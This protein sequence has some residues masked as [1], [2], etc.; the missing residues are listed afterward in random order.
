MASRLDGKHDLATVKVKIDSLFQKPNQLIEREGIFHDFNF[1][2]INFRGII[3]NEKILCFIRV[4]ARRRPGPYAIE[5]IIR[6]CITIFKEIVV[7][8]ASVSKVGRF[9]LI[10]IENLIISISVQIGAA[11]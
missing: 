9:V 4:S 2:S 11:G 8:F 5:S 3:Y 7:K 6:S 1:D 10:L